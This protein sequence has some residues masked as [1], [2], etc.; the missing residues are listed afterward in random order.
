MVVTAGKTIKPGN[1]TRSDWEGGEDLLGEVVFH[2]RFDKKEPTPERSM[3][4]YVPGAGTANTQVLWWAPV[5]RVWGTQASGQGDMRWGWKGK[6][7]PLSKQRI[8]FRFAIQS[9]ATQLGTWFL[10][11]QC[12]VSEILTAQ[13]VRTFL[14]LAL[15]S[16]LISTG[17]SHF[18]MCSLKDLYPIPPGNII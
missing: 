10:R 18:Q 17:F 11:R 3:R 1:M 16:P 8:T 6:Q 15:S 7:G 12:T 5:W 9:P 14:P 2:L 4:K 13:R